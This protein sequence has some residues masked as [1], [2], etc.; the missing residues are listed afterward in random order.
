[1]TEEAQIA[2]E[3]GTLLD[4]ATPTL[5]EGEYFLS[6]GIKGTGEAPEWYKGDK[7]SSVAEQARAYTELEKKFGGFTGAPKDGYAGPEGVDADDGLLAE[8]TEFASTHNM[9]QE[10]FNQAW[11]LLTANE[12][13]YEQVSQEQEIASLGDNAQERIK[14]VEGFL[15]NNLDAETYET[16]RDLVTDA[17]SIQ[18][19]EMIVS[20]T[21]PK[22]LPID[23]GEHPTGM[24]WAD[25]EA[26]MFKRTDDGQL[27]RSI[28]MAHE[29][30]I[31]KMMKEFGGDKPHHH[32]FG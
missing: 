20:A 11:E 15:K 23:G 29:R 8:L 9:N 13:A 5:S 28:D 10:A 30:K 2:E 19:I 18:L 22:K 26:E 6:D 12:E 25:I 4:E 17:K 1:M 3:G 16:A 27:L 32:V 31:Q 21:A 24:S 7:Y 14:N